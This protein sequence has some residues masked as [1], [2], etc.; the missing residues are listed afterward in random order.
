MHEE[1]EDDLEI[2]KP[3]LVVAIAT[4]LAMLRPNVELKLISFIPKS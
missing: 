2:I 3:D 4:T 1:K